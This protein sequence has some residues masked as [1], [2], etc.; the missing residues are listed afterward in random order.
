MNASYWL[1]IRLYWHPLKEMFKLLLSFSSSRFYSGNL[2]TMARRALRWG[3]A[4]GWALVVNP[5]LE[6]GLFLQLIIYLQHNQ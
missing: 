3:R 2:M 5:S 4:L 6:A 1:D